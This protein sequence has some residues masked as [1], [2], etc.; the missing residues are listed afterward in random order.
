MGC[1]KDLGWIVDPLGTALS[2]EGPATLITNPWNIMSAVKNDWSIIKHLLVADMRTDREVQVTSA[3]NARTIVYGRTRVGNQFTYAETTGDKSQIFHII[4]VHAG[5]EIDGYEEIYFDD[6]LVATAATNWV[7]QTPFTGKA[8]IEFFDGTQTAACAS[9][10]AASA[11]VWTP[12]HKL[13]GVAYTHITMT[14]D[15]AVYPT[16]TPVV[17]AVIRGKRVYDPRTGL[18][19]WS[20]NPA[21][22]IRDYMLMP[23]RLGGMGCDLDEIDD[24][25]SVVAA[26]ICDQIVYSYIPPNQ[27][28]GIKTVYKPIPGVDP[29]YPETRYTLNGQIKLDGAPTQFVKDMLT[30]CA[31]EAVYSA[32]QWKLYAG[33]PAATVATI[34]ESWLN[35]GISFKINANKN[36]KV[37]T[38][39]GTFTNSND[40]WADTEFPPVPVGVST[41]PNATYW[42]AIATPSHYDSTLTYVQNAYTTMAGKVYQ[43]YKDTGVPLNEAPPNSTYWVLI[44]EHDGS[45]VYPINYIVQRG[46]TV[47]TSVAIVPA[48]NIYLAEDGGEV[49]TANITLPYTITSS[50]AQRLAKIALEKSRRGL[51]VTYPCNHRAFPIDIMD[52]VAV[53]NT[54]LGW[55]AKLFRVVGWS[56]S[57]MSGTSLELA[58]YDA[59]IYDWVPGDS[60]PLV[61]PIL[62][63][64]P[65]PWSVSPPAGLSVIETLYIGN[66]P[67]LIMT[68]ATFSWISGDA[69]S[70]LYDIYL[71][72]IY[73]LTSRDTVAVISD[74]ST[75]THTFAV[76][77]SNSL[78]ATSI[79]ASI[80]YTVLGKTAPPSDVRGFRITPDKGFVNLTWYTNTDLDI[81]G[82]EIRMGSSWAAGVLLVTNHASSSYQWQPTQP[83]NLQFWIKAIDTTGNYSV[84]AVTVILTINAAVVSEFSQQVID[85]NV[86]LTWTSTPGT[87]AI[88]YAE[89]RQGNSFS[90]AEVIGCISGTFAAIFETDSGN[91]RY[92][93]VLRDIAGLY[94]PQI[95]LTAFVNQPPD[96]VLHDQRA[97]ELTGAFTDCVLDSGN[98]VATANNTETYEAHFT[99][100]SWTTPQNQIDAG[101]PYFIQP[102]PSAGQYVEIID[103]GAL[104]PNT[105]ISMALTKSSITGTVTVTPTISVSANG[106]SWIDYVGVY[107]VFAGNFRYVKITLN[108]ASSDN[109]IVAIT[110]SAVKLEV[111]LKTVQ[112]MC[113]ALWTDTGGTVVDITGQF[114]DVQSISLTPQG[115]AAAIPI[116]DFVDTSYPTQ[117]EIYLFNSSGGRI[118]GTVSYTVRGVIAGTDDSGGGSA[119]SPTTPTFSPSEGS[120]SSYQY[121]VISTETPGGTIYYTLDGTTPTHSSTVYSGRIHVTTDLTINAITALAG[122]VDSA[123]GT[124]NYVMDAVVITPPGAPTIGTALAGSTQ[125]TVAFTPPT[126]NGGETITNYTVT[127]YPGGLVASGSSSPIIV[128]G[129]LNGTN[130]VFRVTATNSAGTGPASAASNSVLP[131]GPISFITN[132]TTFAPNLVLTGSPTITWSFDDGTTSPLA[133]PNH[134]FATGGNH[135]TTLNLSTWSSMVRLNF[136][137]ANVD[138]PAFENWPF[139]N[140]VGVS[141]FGEL[142][143]YLKQWCS[144]PGSQMAAMDFSNFALLTDIRN[145]GGMLT[146]INV[147]GCTGLQRMITEANQLTVLDISTCSSMV[148]LRSA[149]NYITHFSFGSQGSSYRHLCIHDNPLSSNLPLSQFPNL[150]ELLIGNDNQTGAFV[151]PSTALW[152]VNISSNGY[153]SADLTNAFATPNYAGTSIYGF[154]PGELDCRNNS[155]TS[156]NISGCLGITLLEAQNNP[157]TQSAVDGVFSTLDSLGRTGGTVVINSTTAPSVAGRSHAGNLVNKGWTIT[158]DG[159]T[160]MSISTATLGAAAVGLPFSR[161][162]VS[163]NGTGPFTWS[164]LSGSLPTSLSLSSGGVLSGTPTIAGAYSFVVR[165]TDSLGATSDRLFAVSVAAVANYASIAT[166]TASSYNSAGSQSPDKA[167]DGVIDGYG[168]TLTG[169]TGDW[170]KEWATNGEGVGA[171]L[172]LTWGAAYTINQIVLYDR[173]NSGDQITSGTITFSDASSISIGPLNNDGSAT[174]YNFAARSI[175]SLT[176]SVTGVSGSTGSVGL[177]EMQVFHI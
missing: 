87:F 144:Q 24:I 1:G 111:K 12:A 34:D 107:S 152:L 135:T 57:M 31:G 157:L 99:T 62:T 76:K 86:L 59:A 69:Q 158:L 114:L 164:V 116:Y 151:A 122:Y 39:K 117:F 156:L 123:M 53:N 119:A 118:S 124:A 94:G 17:K 52:V 43:A 64:L 54:R 70:S 3:T 13:L 30:S 97:L 129:L 98:L 149:H 20:S 128:N 28:P 130:Y 79:T 175:T 66:V 51:T 36:D 100:H 134:T 101:N 80:S 16:G 170:T 10:I 26:N 8:T 35:G 85:N 150:N 50:E 73:Q 102:T 125:A 139:Q 113:S 7:I 142:A 55:D 153:T 155:L 145:Y 90:S 143:P 154:T 96:Y 167:I 42:N 147:A 136:G 77:A 133:Q 44:E 41:P 163:A 120:Y 9:M 72:G 176:L 159:A 47:Y 75:G 29:T 22:C 68:K 108:F 19:A 112:G 38:A 115:T 11:S 33:A 93:V 46:G 78:G 162:I 49:L 165:V 27:A 63:N 71:D 110:A 37:N 25:S 169:M 84:N 105:K 121:V 58:E 82:Y 141:L 21:L 171:W 92:W 95:S 174:T 15:E 67:S 161:T 23:V 126:D 56:F 6:K 81:A 103:Y 168:G 127:S 2:F 40:Y 74:I 88:D 18:I 146:T 5:H 91:Y 109:G 148:E 160:P 104:I 166:A 48:S 140:L 83:G 172:T 177:A 132:G 137:D 61:A 138:G 45:L 4:C 60:T 89:I 106:T 32:G 131:L 173:P 14:Y 65:N